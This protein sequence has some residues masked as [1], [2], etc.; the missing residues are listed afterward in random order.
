M[1]LHG[2]HGYRELATRVKHERHRSWDNSVS[3]RSTQRQ[4]A[5]KGALMGADP[6]MV[7]VALSIR[8][9]ARA[10]HKRLVIMDAMSL[11]DAGPN[12]DVG[13]A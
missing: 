4:H 1:T 7:S 2:M 12:R 13:R 10:Q 11:F 3:G 5:L 8:A 9:S 6:T